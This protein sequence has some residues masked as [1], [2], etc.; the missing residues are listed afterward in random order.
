MT[1]KVNNSV[2]CWSCNL[3]YNYSITRNLLLCKV[4][5]WGIYLFDI[6]VFFL[7]GGGIEVLK[8]VNINGQL[9]QVE[10]S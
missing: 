7:K 6:I 3:Q 9:F 5:I 8:N 4:R 2:E 1:F 10:L